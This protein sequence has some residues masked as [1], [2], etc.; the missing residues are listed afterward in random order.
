MDACKG[1]LTCHAAAD[2]GLH[3]TYQALAHLQVLKRGL[4]STGL[5][6]ITKYRPGKQIGIE[7]MT[8]CIDT[9]DSPVHCVVVVVVAQTFSVIGHL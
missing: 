8:W 4:K 9:L 2:R 3:V 5:M 7:G 6:Q 1:I